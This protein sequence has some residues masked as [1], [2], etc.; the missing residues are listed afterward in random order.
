MTLTLQFLWNN[1]DKSLFGVAKRKNQRKEAEATS[2]GSYFKMCS[3]KIRGEVIKHDRHR[4]DSPGQ[5]DKAA[6]SEK[7]GAK[8]W[9]GAGNQRGRP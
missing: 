4:R 2:R 6:M 5:R 9:G 1:G 8:G 7:K 3:G